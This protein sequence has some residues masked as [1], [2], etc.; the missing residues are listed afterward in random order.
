VRSEEGPRRGLLPAGELIA[1]RFVIAGPAGTGGMATVYRA[2]DLQSGQD[3]AL[4]VARD[5]A[6]GAS[7]SLIHEAALLASL[8]HPGVVAYVDHGR[9]A[10][11]R[12]FLAI[13][14]V[15]GTSLGAR[16]LRGPLPL[17]DMFEATRQLSSTLAYLHG[18]DVVHGDVKPDNVLATDDGRF[19]LLDFGIARRGA[20]PSAAEAASVAAGTAGYVA[21]EVLR[22]GGTRGGS[23]DLF[24]L[25][26]VAFAMLRG[27]PPFERDSAAGALQALLHEEVPRLDALVPG[28]PAGLASLI[29]VM[30]AR[31][32][33]ARPTAAEARARLDG[34]A[35]EVQQAAVREGLGAKTWM[36][37]EHRTVCHLLVSG[38]P[39]EIE[40]TAAELARGE[41]PLAIQR[42]AGTWSMTPACPSSLAADL[43]ALARLALALRRR[44][45]A[46]GMA[47]CCGPS[48]GTSSPAGP[49]DGEAGRRGAGV[50]ALDPMAAGLL[51]R[52]FHIV[53]RDGLD[54]LAG[55]SLGM[56]TPP[57]LLGRPTP[58]LGRSRETSLLCDRFREVVDGP[59]A[60]LDVVTGLPG[61]GKSRLVYEVVKGLQ[62]EGTGAHLLFA[63]ARAGAAT[64]ALGVLR[65]CIEAAVAV[66]PD[67]DLETRQ[68]KLTAHLRFHFPPS[69]VE[70]LAPFIGELASVPFSE[71]GNAALH[72]ARL[73]P[74]LMED[75]MRAA[76]HEWLAAQARSA[77]VV[78][79]IEDAHE[80]DP[81]TTSFLQ[82]ALRHLEHAPFWILATTT[83][84]SDGHHGFAELSDA[85][86]QE[87]LLGPLPDEA[88][89][90]LAAA[91]LGKEIASDERRA[92]L[93]RCQGNPFYLEELIRAARDGRGR[94]LPSSVLEMIR[95]RLDVEPPDA[96]L[97]LRAASVLGPTFRLVE[98]ADLLQAMGREAE[99]GRWLRHLCDREILRE[100]VAGD[101]STATYAFAHPSFCEASYAS[102]T[103]R[104][105]RVA[106][107]AAAHWLA[108]TE[109]PEALTVAE[110]FRR[111][112][113]T[114]LAAVWFERAAARA[115][116][117]NDLRGAL[118]NVEIAL[119]VVAA[120]QDAAGRLRATLARLSALRAEA[121]LWCG[122]LRPAE[123]AAT[124]AADELEPGDAGWLRA[125]GTGVIA[126]GKQAEWDHVSAWVARA[127]SFAPAA[128]AHDA[129]AT[130]LAWASVFLIFGGRY[131]EADELTSMVA[132]LARPGGE[133]DPEVEALLAQSRAVRA[134]VAGD[135]AGC[136]AQLEQAQ[137]A[138]EQAQDLRNLCT[139]RTNLAFVHMELGDVGRAVDGLRRAWEEAQEMGLDDVSSIALH[140]LGRALAL[141]GDLTAGERM[142][143]LAV[144]RLAKEGER[145]LEALSRV[146]LA[147][148]LAAT[149]APEEAIG[150]AKLAVAALDDNPGLRPRAW[151]A[152]A[153]ALGAR[154]LHEEAL[155]AAR[156]AWQMLE[157]Q[158]TVE[159]G[160]AL[161]RLRYA[162]CLAACARTHEA[163]AA[164]RDAA[165]K[166]VM[167]AEKISDRACRDRF[168]TRVP[169]NARTLALAESL[170]EV[171]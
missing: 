164:I 17:G 82:S 2:A 1:G 73:H 35:D 84:R 157:A 106:H 98:V 76:W 56:A 85:S 132:D 59:R 80:A 25:G 114:D 66:T 53:E 20:A 50:V 65:Q 142:E 139:A 6:A 4:K 45:P 42:G 28:V 51:R 27:R 38:A 29:S 93:A 116:R 95:L 115:L 147:E 14:W 150:Q 18:A 107:L 97:V 41:G 104:D 33:A 57:S 169:E 81:R 160:E 9:C 40:E 105:R 120:E 32:P 99:G 78:L 16:L 103:A 144:E 111:A 101:A 124:L 75:R 26:C 60:R 119:G 55:E 90:E 130:T 140:N 161:V 67:D 47:L 63:A 149:P 134:S 22:G 49:S 117:A 68:R 62:R 34:L 5:D 113:A 131:D 12:P 3:V 137:A 91:A 108:S 87:T 122:E 8:V 7:E 129:L 19:V 112:G 92:L 128:D 152:L 148:I 155:E 39:E 143:R 11:G 167:R 151:A 159:E 79:V 127:T 146:Y 37:G 86:A 21:P 153:A 154:G 71:A 61:V 94:E 158:G 138:F 58:F 13:A 118:K 135:L 46:A 44:F 88:C 123:G 136:L 83:Q 43:E 133:G 162:E 64:I 54:L 171:A 96:R 163:A 125:I 109:M 31:D 70:R 145:R 89:A 126:A 48:E 165:T 30:L 156:A 52:R 170:G 121:H 77:P 168:L 15:S 23:A 166:L 102:L 36:H 69:D 74:Q 100:V 10:D 24:S 141:Q 110:H 72:A